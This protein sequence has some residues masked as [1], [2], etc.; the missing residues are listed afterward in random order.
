MAVKVG[1]A[2]RR[3]IE[4]DESPRVLYRYGAQEHCVDEAENGGVRAN[5][6]RQGQN[7]NSGEPWRFAQYAQAEA[8]ILNQVLKPVHFARVAAFLFGLLDTAQVESRTAMRLFSRHPL[9]DVFF[10]CSFEV[11]TQLVVQF[12]VCLRPAKQRPQPQWNRE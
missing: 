5:A 10:G 11:V 8:Q 3:P 9:R 6:E 12:L 1:L 7:S 2:M 4:D